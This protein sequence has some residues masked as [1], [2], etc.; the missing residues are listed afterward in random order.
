MFHISS[1]PQCDVSVTIK[2]RKDCDI[3][4]LLDCETCVFMTGVGGDELKKNVSRKGKLFQKQK[5]LCTIF[6]DKTFH[7][8]K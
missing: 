1:F 5:N 3:T 6:K 4:L 7:F 8:L 2:S